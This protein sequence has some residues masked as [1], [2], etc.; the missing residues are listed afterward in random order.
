MPAERDRLLESQ[1]R[2][3]HWRRW[4]PYLAERSWGNPREDYSADGTAWDYFTHDDARSRAY[5]WTEDGIC[6]I[7]D[8][9]Q[10]LCFAFAFWNGRDAILKERL[11]GLSGHG[12][13]HG[14]DVKEYYY[15]LD[16]TPTHSYMKAL[17]KYPQRAF[18]Y[19]ELVAE[20]R[21]RGKVETEYE[22]LDTGIFAEDRYFDITVEYAKVDAEDI[23]I[24][25]TAVNR[26]PDAAPLHVLPTLWFRNTW[27]WGYDHD[28]ANLRPELR[29]AE[30]HAEQNG[31]QTLPLIHASHATLGEYWLVGQYTGNEAQALF[32]ENES[33]AQ[34]LW[35][36]PNAT[37]FVKDGINN[38]VV[39]GAQGA[40]NPQGFA[41]KTAFHYT[42]AVVPGATE[43]V[44]LRL[45]AS[46]HDDPFAD[47][48]KVFEAR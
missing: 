1:R 12:G 20:N 4:G 3:K 16:S 7:C 13:N 31:S 43:T 47:A 23:L 46:R 19:A 35:G 28:G 45:S 8:N 24:R 38:A 29:I 33:N 34:R 44:L 42:F 37:P 6:G 27:A 14:E 9:H 10:R 48:A 11:F 17:Y 36:V 26:G 22:L 18:P 40:G 30:T 39:S 41:T 21:R 15:Y 32:T 5:R 25:I 2:D